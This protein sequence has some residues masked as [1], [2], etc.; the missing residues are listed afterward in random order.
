MNPLTNVKN[1][2]KLSQRE[3]ELGVNIKQS[4]HQQYRDSAWVFL[5]GLNYELTEGDIICV[6][7]QYG[8]IVSINLVRDKKTGKSKG[9]AFLCYEDQRSTILAVDNLNG[10]KLASRIIRVDHVEEY[11]VPKMR[12]DMSEEQQKLLMEGC[13]PK[14]I[15]VEE[16]EKE[17]ELMV[18][19]PEQIKKEKN[20]KKVKKEKKKKKDK[21]KKKKKRR[22]SS[23]S[24]SESESDSSSSSD[25]DSDD[26]SYKKKRKKK[27]KKRSRDESESE[28]NSGDSERE[29]KKNRARREEYGN[30]TYVVKEEKRDPGYEKY[31]HVRQDVDRD[32]YRERDRGQ[33]RY[34]D[35][36][37]SRDN[38]DR[39]YNRHRMERDDR[40]RRER[41]YRQDG[42]GGYRQGE[43]RGRGGNRDG[44]YG[45]HNRS[46]DRDRYRGRR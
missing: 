40:E 6:F 4:W 15:P 16:Q 11:K 20:D 37:D 14:L 41:E 36:R 9:F 28:S 30:G 27:K 18:I 23:S 46:P 31:E 42:R 3:L 45:S 19:P 25:S 29:R 43:D 39:E 22:S 35:V 33:E 17:E 32:R 26:D 24:S 2:Q 7:S 12:E 21:K 13:A 38:R 44:R 5:G 10:I 34:R 1:I 8:E